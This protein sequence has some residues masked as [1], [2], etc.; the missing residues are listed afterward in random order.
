MDEEELEIVFCYERAARARRVL[1]AASIAEQA[2]GADTPEAWALLFREIE[3]EGLLLEQA[4]A[5]QSFARPLET[6]ERYILPAVLRLGD[7][8]RFLRYGAMAATLRG[9][10]EN[11]FAAG[12]LPAL[13]K[14][15]RES[16]ARDLAARLPSLAARAEAAAALAAASSQSPEEA[17][18]LER[19]ALDA[20]SRIQ[21]PGD[22]ASA[23]DLAAAL[24]GVAQHLPSRLQAH[25]ARYLEDL[26]P[27]PTLREDVRQAIIGAW[28]RR[29]EAP[30]EAF[31]SL[32]LESPDPTAWLDD[33]PRRLGE[34]VSSEEL[35]ERLARLPEAWAPLSQRCLAAALG[36]AARE[37]FETEALELWRRAGEPYAIFTQEACR[38]L[39][40]AFLK[41]LGE[42]ELSAFEKALHPRERARV[43]LV[44][45]E[46]TKDPT[47]SERV[48][49]LL[50]AEKTV[51]ADPSLQLRLLEISAADMSGSLKRP[52]TRVAIQLESLGFEV[53]VEDLARYLDLVAR[54]LPRRLAGAVDT[55][56]ASRVGTR[57]ILLGLAR[58]A[59][60]E[61]TLHELL[62][63]AEVLAA[64][65][66][67]D[68]AQGFRLRAELLIALGCRLNEAEARPAVI[69][70]VLSRLLP[71][72]SDEL[73]SAL[74]ETHHAHGRRRQAAEAARRIESPSRRLAALLRYLEEP[75]P[76]ALSPQNLFR[77]AADVSDLEDEL[78]ALAV[79]QELP[80]EPALLG[81]R[82]TS[83]VRSYP[84]R[85]LALA[86]LAHH[87]LDFERRTLPA[88]RRDRLAAVLPLKGALGVVE[89]EAWLSAFTPELVALG[90][91]FGPR[92]ALAEHQEAAERLLG[93]T[94]VA[95]LDRRDALEALLSRLTR[96]APEGPAF[97][98]EVTAAAAWLGRFYRWL[99]RRIADDGIKEARQ[100]LSVLLVA[101]F[102]A[103]PQGI[104]ET[105]QHPRL[106]F[107]A[108]LLHRL[109]GG[110]LVWQ[111]VNR[112]R[113]VLRKG[114]QGSGAAESTWPSSWPPP[115]LDRKVLPLLWAHPAARRRTARRCLSSPTGLNA[116]GEALSYLLAAREPQ[117]AA[118]LASGLSPEGRRDAHLLRMTR[119][120]WLAS[121]S[122]DL[123]LASG[124][125]N[126]RRQQLWAV[127][128]RVDFLGELG[129]LVRRGAL[130][131]WH[132]EQIPLRRQLWRLGSR[133]ASSGLG[134]EAVAAFAASGR[135]GGSRAL[136]WW[137]N[138][139]LA[140]ELGAESPARRQKLT[141]L[142]EALEASK[143]LGPVE[144]PRPS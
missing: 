142:L 60:Q 111:A 30:N 15:G 29:G 8:V 109:P 56:L 71:E 124:E 143:R 66:A 37:G 125:E 132:P 43:Y 21:Q 72:E 79:L 136:L 58:Q 61:A 35:R 94:T 81:Q 28:L 22:E 68:G 86:D 17:Q 53:P 138:S 74:A 31:W 39:G 100:D 24:R 49:Q 46:E 134:A 18:E 27:W 65:V 127:P 107:W 47:M 95:W 10:A 99:A 32:L 73:W 36:H 92:H 137:L 126:L 144:G 44:V 104:R 67:D 84:R 69:S 3:G 123:P 42:T 140:P 34:L 120:R 105:L 14:G 45:A 90:S 40:R 119:H 118:K 9:L 85:L 16:M 63:R 93:L 62:R 23:R 75:D 12:V 103:L 115:P 19:Q 129:S 64:K 102:E 117:L 78:R 33:L 98:P 97:S 130:D 54:V 141:E 7:E 80:T 110:Y 13:M 89:S 83:E 25:G 26:S 51:P 4:E 38:H 113:Q 139:V 5:F 57:E 55:L 121:A 2:G 70:E 48:R 133:E 128:D 114:T 6:L 101:S 116:R 50:E 52:L 82:I 91:V 135:E 11:L 131:L 87:T 96:H 20:L 112:F 76:E 108:G 1:W 122:T 77:A 41:R 59:R 88:S 106:R